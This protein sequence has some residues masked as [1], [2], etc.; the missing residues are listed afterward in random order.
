MV[1][2]WHHAIYNYVGSTSRSNG[3]SGNL[4]LIITAENGRSPRGRLFLYFLNISEAALNPF[5]VADSRVACN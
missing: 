2:E 4:P 3:S 5:M 1:S